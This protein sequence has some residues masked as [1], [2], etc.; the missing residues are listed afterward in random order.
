MSLNITD[1][2]RPRDGGEKTVVTSVN[3]LVTCPDSQ[4]LRGVIAEE[5]V[6]AGRMHRYAS[7]V[8]SLMLSIYVSDP[9]NNVNNDHHGPAPPNFLHRGLCDAIVNWNFQQAGIDRVNNNYP[10]LTEALQTLRE[11][12]ITFP[13]DER[14]N[15]GRSDGPTGSTP[16]LIG[17][18]SIMIIANIK[19]SVRAKF[20]PFI[21]DTIN[22]ILADPTNRVGQRRPDGRLSITKKQKTAIKKE[23]IRQITSPNTTRPPKAPT[24]TPKELALVEFHR[25]GFSVPGTDLLDQHRNQAIDQVYI[26]SKEKYYHYF[27]VHFARCLQKIESLCKRHPKIKLRG[28]NHCLGLIYLGSMFLLIR[29]ASSH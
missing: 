21:K 19:T 3:R 8:M 20:L 6:K 26:K 12:G 17:Y 11:Q 23:I 18:L 1:H 28:D 24:L 10:L 9:D 2:V 22:A 13:K 29:R 5:S 27:I 25:R 16:W 4:I 15:V 14:R 7:I